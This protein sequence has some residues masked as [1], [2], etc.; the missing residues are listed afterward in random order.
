M[1]NI[2]FYNSEANAVG[3]L[4]FHLALVYS[5]N[6][7]KDLAL[8]A[9]ENAENNFKTVLSSDDPVFEVINQ[10]KSQFNAE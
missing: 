8:S 1:R 10:F 9:L 2:E 4:S 3:N 6:G 5:E 7:E